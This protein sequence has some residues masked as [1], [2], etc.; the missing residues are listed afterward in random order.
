MTVTD[1]CSFPL[2][3]RIMFTELDELVVRV[4]RV[5]LLRFSLPRTR[6]TLDRKY[7]K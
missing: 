6:A 1:D 3:L 2:R 5:R 4:R 7:M